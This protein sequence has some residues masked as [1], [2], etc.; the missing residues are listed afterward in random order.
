MSNKSVLAVENIRSLALPEQRVRRLDGA[1]PLLRGLGSQ[2]LHVDL[3]ERRIERF[4]R[5]FAC[6]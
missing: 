1:R 5:L 3:F 4:Q 6:L 2:L